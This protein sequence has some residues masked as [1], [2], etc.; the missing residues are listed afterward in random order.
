MWFWQARPGGLQLEGVEELST[1]EAAALRGD[2]ITRA[3]A[4]EKR[5]APTKHSLPDEM[6]AYYLRY[7]LQ[8]RYPN[9]IPSG[10]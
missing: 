5:N 4:E 1:E 7:F 6:L 10:E 9:F 2:M 8:V 3:L